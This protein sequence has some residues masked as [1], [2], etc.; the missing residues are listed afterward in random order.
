MR[1]N[2]AE[3]GLT[4]FFPV[5]RASGPRTMSSA[6]DIT[7]PALIERPETTI[8]GRKGLSVT[9]CDTLLPQVPYTTVTSDIFLAAGRM[10]F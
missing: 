2:N 7:V 6:S 8:L 5:L 1:L 3:P 9:V 4:A 10:P